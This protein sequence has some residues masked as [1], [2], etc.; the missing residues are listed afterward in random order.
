MCEGR[1]CYT[2]QQKENLIIQQCRWE[3]STRE[4][5]SGRG[6]FERLRV[7]CGQAITGV[8]NL[9]YVRLIDVGNEA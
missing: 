3:E 2:N 9:D 8:E 4:G 7:Q 5:E 1:Y 6:E